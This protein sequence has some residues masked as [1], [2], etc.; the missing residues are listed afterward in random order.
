[1]AAQV[2]HFSPE[3]SGLRKYICVLGERRDHGRSVR[4]CRAARCLSHGLQSIVSPAVYLLMLSSH[5]DNSYPANTVYYTRTMRSDKYLKINVNTFSSENVSSACLCKGKCF[6][7]W[8][9]KKKS[10]LNRKPL[11]HDAHYN[12]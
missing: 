2:G 3:P 8:I 9:S 10:A 11:L 5:C 7:D 4:A 12:K 6:R 1:M